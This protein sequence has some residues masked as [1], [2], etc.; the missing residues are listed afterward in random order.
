VKRDVFQKCSN[1]DYPQPFAFNTTILTLPIIVWPLA[2]RLSDRRSSRHS[3]Q[4][5]LE[6][7]QEVLTPGPYDLVWGIQSLYIPSKLIC[8]QHSNTLCKLFI[9]HTAQPVLCWPNARRFSLKSIRSFLNTAPNIHFRHIFLQNPWY[10]HRRNGSN[11]RD[12]RTT[13][14]P[15][16]FHQGRSSL[17]TVPSTKR[18]GYYAAP[19]M[20]ATLQIARFLRRVS[21]WR[22]LPLPH[23]YWLILS[24]PSSRGTARKHR[25]QKLSHLG[26]LF[27][28]AAVG[29]K[30]ESVS[31]H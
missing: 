3:W 2:S 8:A 14:Y 24:V 6:H 22:P 20:A 9:R 12:S 4:T 17:G 25:L 15:Y 19:E 29:G 27:T 10:G 5:T 7:A 18:H 21:P 30:K 16:H 23:P 28:T 26:N 11:E 13:M 1:P 31:P